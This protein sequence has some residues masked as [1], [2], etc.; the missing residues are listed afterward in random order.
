MPIDIEEYARRVHFYSDEV[1]PLL[2]EY[3]VRS[4]WKSFADVGCGDGAL[5]WALDRRGLFR[6]K[7]VH[8]IDLS[9]TRVE[10]AQQINP[11]FHC[12]VGSATELACLADSSIDFLVST[13]VI[14]HVPDDN[15]MVRAM[16]R[17]LRPGGTVFLSTVHK[18][19][20][21]W[22]F[23]RCNGRWVLD[24]TH[25]REYKDDRQLLSFF[26]A[27]GFQVVENRKEQ[28]FFPLVDFFL[29]RLGVSRNA[30]LKRFTAVLRK[31]KVPIIGYY[32]W[33]LI[34]RCR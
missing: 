9:R 33:E 27:A 29:R 1:S 7:E 20:Y 12:Q 3:L 32:N 21:G 28:F 10:L 23:Y 15:D 8:G 25:L 30:S 22:Y 18:K 24:P 2:L 16:A 17:V 31:L 13:Q 5:L 11:A 6:D 34:L 26:E 4:E 19:W 14:E